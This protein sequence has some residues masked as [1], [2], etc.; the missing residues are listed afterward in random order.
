[1]ISLIPLLPV[2]YGGWIELNKYVFHQSNYSI[3]DEGKN[4]SL[5][6]NHKL[7]F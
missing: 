5:I 1:M 6:S 3:V 4:K 2:S 7:L